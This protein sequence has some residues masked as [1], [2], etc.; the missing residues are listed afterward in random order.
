MPNSYDGKNHSGYFNSL[1]DRATQ[2]SEQINEVQKG[3]WI[4]QNRLRELKTQRL[5]VEDKMHHSL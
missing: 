5:R 2:L 3:P 4:D 1:N